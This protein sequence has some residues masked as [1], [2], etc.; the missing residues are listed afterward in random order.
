[1]YW[2]QTRGFP[3][4]GRDIWRANGE[5]QV[6]SGSGG[7]GGLCVAHASEDIQEWWS[8]CLGGEQHTRGGIVPGPCLRAG[9]RTT[10]SLGVLPPFPAA[11]APPL[12]VLSLLPYTQPYSPTTPRCSPPLCSSQQL[13][14]YRLQG[15]CLE[16]ETKAVRKTPHG[17]G[18]RANGERQV[19][20]GSGGGGGLCVAHASEDI[21]E[22]WS[23]C[24]AGE[25]H[26]RAGI[27]SG[28]CR[29]GARTTLS[30]GVLPP[31]P[32]AA[33]PP[34]SVLSPLPYT[35]PYSPTTPRCL[36]PLC[37][38]QHLWVSSRTCPTL[39]SAP[40]LPNTRNLPTIFTHLSNCHHRMHYCS[41]EDNN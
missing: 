21:Q 23:S 9:T 26:T 16:G 8:S 14:L 29:A 30:L 31:F 38:Q 4:R 24:L 34:L 36:P 37:S 19:A 41:N 15:S 1:L 6:A 13:P 18:W 11:A 32:A 3:L 20:S 10:L 27:V 17:A 2:L 7:G 35:R 39:S 5:G 28:P 40:P 33:A 25:Q 22:C 12:S